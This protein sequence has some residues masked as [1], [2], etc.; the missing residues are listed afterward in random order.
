NSAATKNPFARINNTTVTRPR[1]FGIVS[2][3]SGGR[4]PSGPRWDT[5]PKRV[6]RCYCRCHCTSCRR[7]TTTVRL[8]GGCQ[9]RSMQDHPPSEPAVLTLTDVT[10]RKGDT[11]ILRDVDWEVRSDESWVVLGLNGSGKSSLIRVASLYEHPSSGTV[12]VL[13]E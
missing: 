10:L 6:K 2:S 12:D 9:T 13:G 1:A 5:E 3:R 7:A 8:G 11:T 4:I